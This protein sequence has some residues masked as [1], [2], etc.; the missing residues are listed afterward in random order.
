M[1]NF[2]KRVFALISVFVLGFGFVAC[3]EEEPQDTTFDF[4]VM[5]SEVESADSYI[6]AYL[7]NLQLSNSSSEVLA[8]YSS[9]AKDSFA[10]SLTIV[11]S[12]SSILGTFSNLEE[13][14]KAV[15]ETVSQSATK[16]SITID[17][18]EILL[19]R[20]ADGVNYSIRT[21][22]ESSMLLVEFIKL[23]EGKYAV[24]IVIWDSSVSQYNTFQLLFHGYSGK[25]AI[26]ND[27]IT[28]APIFATDILSASF[29][30]DDADVQFSF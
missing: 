13:D 20:S 26:D 5:K 16:F 17:G 1:H 25:F 28:Y 30:F 29:P 8:G 12:C 3:K 4:Y 23:D 19:E 18:S 22:S 7:N 21:S 11:Q 2:T 9:T 10:S 27:A 6:R 15:L 14:E 24:Q